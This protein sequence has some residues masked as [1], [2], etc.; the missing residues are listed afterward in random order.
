MIPNDAKIVIVGAGAIGGS[1][2][3]FIKSGY[4]H[5]QCRNNY[6]SRNRERPETNVTR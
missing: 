3:A 6:G 5:K 4:S 2:A 1:T